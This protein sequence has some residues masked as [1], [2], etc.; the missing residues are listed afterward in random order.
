MAQVPT[1]N[2][3][4]G[5]CTIPGADPKLDAMES[6]V[7]GEKGDDHAEKIMKTKIISMGVVNEK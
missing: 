7:V 3:G 5:S 1:T 4:T 2:V 6:S